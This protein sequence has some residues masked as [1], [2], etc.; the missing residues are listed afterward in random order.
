MAA[1][2]AGTPSSD[3]SSLQRQKQFGGRRWGMIHVL[4]TAYK[5]MAS[6]NCVSFS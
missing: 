2:E 1:E 3:A 5:K 4:M 6:P